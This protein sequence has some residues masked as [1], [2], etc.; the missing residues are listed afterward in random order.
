MEVHHAPGHGKAKRGAVAARPVGQRLASRGGQAR[1]GRRDRVLAE[2]DGQLP[3]G[4]VRADANP[5]HRFAAGLQQAKQYAEMLG[6]ETVFPH[7]LGSEGAG[8]VAAVGHAAGVAAAVAAR[9]GV[10]LRS[11]AVAAIQDERRRQDATL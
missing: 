10:P 5:E 7:I 6:L 3:R 8:T 4:G 2:L 9:A 1:H 11:V